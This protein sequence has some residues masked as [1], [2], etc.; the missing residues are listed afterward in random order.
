MALEELYEEGKIRA[1]GISNFSAERMADIATFS[2][3]VPAVN[4][5]ETHPIVERIA[6]AHGK[7]P[8]Q[9]ALRFQ[10][11][12]GVV[13]IP[14]T[15]SRERMKENIAL[16]DFTLS[17]DEIRELQILDENKSLWAAYDDPMIVEYAMS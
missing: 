2:K 4:Q 10:V 17:E 8:T 14:K 16:F 15:T 12:R 9:V 13:V 5:V 7:T 3:I 11:Q 6:I 1:I